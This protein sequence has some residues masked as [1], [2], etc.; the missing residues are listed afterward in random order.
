[1]EAMEAMRQ[2]QHAIAKAFGFERENT[3]GGCLAYVRHFA[4][5]VHAI[6]TDGDGDLPDG[7]DW[8][9]GAYNADGEPLEFYRRGDCLN[10]YA[11][12]VRDAVQYAQA[13]TPTT[14]ALA[15]EYAAWL[16]ENNLPNECAES[17]LLSVL[18]W[19]HWLEDF[20]R[21]WNEVQAKEDFERACRARGEAV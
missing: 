2:A 20:V 13:N 19:R 10:G 1:M 21:R 18:G 5:G 4:G 9:V 3:G 14:D 7:T 6:V 15:D 11:D 16:A 8:L 17:L 12:A